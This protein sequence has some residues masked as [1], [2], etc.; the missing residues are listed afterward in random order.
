MEMVSSLWRYTPE[1]N[2]LQSLHKLKDISQNPK[3]VHDACAPS[4]Y[5]IEMKSTINRCTL[6]LSHKIV[7]SG[8]APSERNSFSHAP[9]EVNVSINLNELL[10]MVAV[11][12]CL[13]LV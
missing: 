11:V 4:E 1:Q 10:Q 6:D 12:T 3:L 13:A 2:I 5:G 8:C 7:E 9:S